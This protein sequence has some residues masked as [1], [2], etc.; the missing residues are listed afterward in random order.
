MGYGTGLAHWL[1]QGQTCSKGC[2]SPLAEG[3]AEVLRPVTPLLLL[4]SSQA[5]PIATSFIYTFKA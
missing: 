2:R 3:A 4:C 1:G 5:I